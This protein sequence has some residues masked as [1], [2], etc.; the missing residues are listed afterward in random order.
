MTDKT[1]L[2]EKQKEEISNLNLQIGIVRGVQV[3][4]IGLS[5]YEIA[6][7]N[8]GY[9]CLLWAGIIAAYM[10]LYAMPGLPDFL[11]SDK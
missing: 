5:I 2:P 1:E 11:K 3:F 4:I 8:R 10:Q 7:G 6:S 9:D